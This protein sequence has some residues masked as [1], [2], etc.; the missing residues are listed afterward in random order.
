MT[1]TMSSPCPL[2]LTPLLLRSSCPSA[3]RTLSAA[4]PSSPAS[5]CPCPWPPAPAPSTS[6]QASS[7]SSSRSSSSSPTTRTQTA[8]MVRACA[9]HCMSPW[10]SLFP[11]GAC[12]VQTEIQCDMRL[13]ALCR[14]WTLRL[15]TFLI[16]PLLRPP[17]LRLSPLRP[18]SSLPS[19][20]EAGRVGVP[21]SLRRLPIFSIAL[22]PTDQII[23]LASWP[24]QALVRCVRWVVSVPVQVMA[25]LVYCLT[26][27]ALM[28]AAQLRRLLGGGAS[29]KA[30]STSPGGSHQTVAAPAAAKAPTSLAAPPSQAPVSVDAAGHH[31]RS[32]HHLT[33]ATARAISS[34]ING[35]TTAVPAQIGDASVATA[36][37]KVGPQPTAAGRATQA[38]IGTVGSRKA[39]HD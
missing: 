38:T 18:S 26:A 28:L 7:R 6:A 30:S 24:V 3:S 15:W 10:R 23:R 16:G 21:S 37:L 20:S 4:G 12:R 35:S 27:P 14:L 11:P 5:A 22:W 32:R 2:L 36:S 34:N 39:H 9:A 13:R 33:T 19:R 25:T 1:T 8:C 17:S 29:R 31:D